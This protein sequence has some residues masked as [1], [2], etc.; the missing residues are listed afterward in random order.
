ME[1]VG[2]GGGV[3]DR[4]RCAACQRSGSNSSSCPVGVL[5][6]RLSTSCRY[7]HGSTASRLHVEVKLI[8][9]AAV[10]PPCGEPTNN[11]FF[12][13]IAIRFISRSAALLSIARNPASV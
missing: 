10:R 3:A 11:Q 2:V 6:K 5:G 1:A 8:S 7:D 4:D 12:R 13:P 9:T